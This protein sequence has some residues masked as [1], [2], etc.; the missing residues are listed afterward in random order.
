M[1]NL[2]LIKLKKKK[3]RGRKDLRYEYIHRFLETKKERKIEKERN[4]LC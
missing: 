3:E 2:K 4:N 1:E